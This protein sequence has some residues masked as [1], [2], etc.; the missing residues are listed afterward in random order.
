MKISPSRLPLAVTMGEPAGVGGEITLKAWANKKDS[1]SPFFIIADATQLRTV[2]SLFNIECPIVTIESPSTA[3]EAF[4][5]GLPVL[6][7]SKEITTAVNL[8]NPRP[9]T[10]HSVISAIKQAVEIVK[11]GAARAMI[12]NPI[13]KAT[14]QEAG[15]PFPGHTEY[16]GHLSNSASPVMMLAVEG[17]RAVPVTVHVAIKDVAHALST[18]AIVHCGRVTERAL[19]IDFGIQTPRIAVAALNPHGGE[20]GRLGDEEVDI[21]APAIVQLQAEGIHVSGPAPA[22]TL[23]HKS[24]RQNYDAA[25]CMYHDQAL[26]PL[27]TIDFANGVNATLGIPFVRTSPDHGTACDIA[28]KGIADPSSLIAALDMASAMASSREKFLND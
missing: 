13:Q 19:R 17:L 10:A 11:A 25:L 7:L 23:F 8:Q 20:N 24:A 12:T 4:K 14:L 9:E 28:A 1:A 18:E 2:A 26:I 27:K 5:S 21:I 22:D 3:A 16:L 6:P 15:F